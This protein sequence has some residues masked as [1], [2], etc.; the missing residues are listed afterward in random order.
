MDATCQFVNSAP[1]AHS[2]GYLLIRQNLTNVLH[3]AHT[4]E[5]N[6]TQSINNHLEFL[7]VQVVYDL[8]HHFVLSHQHENIVKR[9]LR[10]L[11]VWLQ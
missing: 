4:M 2:C 7:S 3:I 8:S 11:E 1:T 6:V 5:V 10:F 9:Y